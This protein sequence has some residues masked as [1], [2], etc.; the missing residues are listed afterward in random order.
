MPRP[1]HVEPVVDDHP[2]AVEATGATIVV[3]KDPIARM[4][5]SPTFTGTGGSRLDLLQADN[6]VIAG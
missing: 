2:R 1:V 3:G 4:G 6:T 5:W